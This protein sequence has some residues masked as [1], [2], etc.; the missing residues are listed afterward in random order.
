MVQRKFWD[1]FKVNLSIPSS[2]LPLPLL[3]SFF[4]FFLLRDFLFSPFPYKLIWKFLNPSKIKG[5]CWL[6]YLN[7]M[8]TPG[9]LKLWNFAFPIICVFC[10]TREQ[11]VDHI[12]LRCPFASSY[13]S[14]FLNLFNI[15]FVIPV[16]F[17]VLLGIIG[18]QIHSLKKAKPYGNVYLGYCVD[19]LDRRQQAYLLKQGG[20]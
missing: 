18:F 10:W 16:S 5:F 15:N 4:L 3:S 17:K 9:H 11:S 13:W 8:I 6:A 14:F 7:K 20:Y 12:F 2:E 19:P 1:L